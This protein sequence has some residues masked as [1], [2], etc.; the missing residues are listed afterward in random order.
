VNHKKSCQNDL[1]YFLKGA[2]RGKEIATESI[3]SFSSAK[4]ELKN[5]TPLFRINLPCREGKQ[6]GNFLGEIKANIT[7]KEETGA[8]RKGGKAQKRGGTLVCTSRG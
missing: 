6:E 7:T 5:G 2:V 1:S 3:S 4:K 8:Y